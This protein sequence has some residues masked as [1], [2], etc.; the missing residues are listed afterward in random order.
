MDN[1]PVILR[2]EG[3]I[4]NNEY[5]Q[6][7]D[8]KKWKLRADLMTDRVLIRNASEDQIMRLI[9]LLKKHKLKDLESITF[10]TDHYKERKAFLKSLF[11]QI[12]AAGGLVV[13]NDKILMIYRNKK[14]DLPKGKLEREESQEEGAVRE[15][16]EECGVRVKLV[17]KICTTYHTYLLNGKGILKKNLWYLMECENDS[18]MK[19]QIEEGIEE[20]RW[21]DH[22]EVRKCLYNTFPSIREVFQVYYENQKV[23]VTKLQKDA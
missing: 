13:K 16:E 21:M 22:R 3:D 18:D 10:T 17:D 7:I 20:V 2:E 23:D 19:P 4:D 15:V 11:T 5:D 8:Q 1:I 12:K 9:D 6:I 14:W